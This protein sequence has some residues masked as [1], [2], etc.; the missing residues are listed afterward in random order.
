MFDAAIRNGIVVDGSR[1]KPYAACVYIQ[2]GKIAEI[3]RDA[4]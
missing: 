3:S 2:G 1:A 4:E